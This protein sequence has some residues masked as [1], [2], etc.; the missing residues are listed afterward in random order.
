M[1]SATFTAE[2]EPEPRY[3][4]RDFDDPEQR[5]EFER[6][7]PPTKRSRPMRAFPAARPG[8]GV[9]CSGTASTAERTGQA[10]VPIIGVRNHP[11]ARTAPAPAVD[12]AVGASSADPR[13]RFPTPWHAEARSR[14]IEHHNGDAADTARRSSEKEHRD[15]YAITSNDRPPSEPFTLTHVD[16]CTGFRERFM[17]EKDDRTVMT[18]IDARGARL[19]RPVLVVL[20]VSTLAVIGIFSLLYYGTYG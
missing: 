1:W 10:P 17:H 12:L 11:Q 2:D 8:A 3:N 7:Y 14:S 18:A 4:P 20:I 6:R 15:A 19:G 13:R 9:C 16:T 5:R